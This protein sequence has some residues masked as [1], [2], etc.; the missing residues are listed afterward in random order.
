MK[1]QESHGF[2]LIELLTVIAIISILAAFT[3]VTLPRVRE[4]AKVARV[5]ND[6]RQLQVALAQYA[7]QHG[8][9]PPA[10]G[11][12]T[13]LSRVY[14]DLEDWENFH[15]SSYMSL[16]NL[17]GVADL[18]DEF[19]DSYNTERRG[20]D[21][22]SL[23]EFSPIED[24]TEDVDPDNATSLTQFLYPNSG[25]VYREYVSLY[26]GEDENGN[27]LNAEK[28]D[29]RDRVNRRRFGR[30]YVYIPVNLRQFAL[31]KRFC[32]VEMPINDNEPDPLARKSLA[33]LPLRFPPPSYDAYVLISMGP[34][35][36]TAGLLTA[37]ASFL[38]GIDVEDYYLVLGLRAYYLATRD[39]NNNQRLDFDFRE[40]SRNR[41]GREERESEFYQGRETLADGALWL[42]PDGSGG[43]GPMILKQE[44]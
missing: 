40:R 37:P 19:S 5:E 23:L 11:Y 14:S 7:V 21:R 29:N 2:T 38:D 3:A 41:E 39:L 18:Y 12:R 17:V 44:G 1:S 34:A 20:S 31:V 30:P 15:L 13:Q 8:S 16:L 42:L 27:P 43:V 9:Y 28:L 25:S 4:R 10:Y 33:D 36:S 26:L 32:E 24:P 35:E 6:L 22:I